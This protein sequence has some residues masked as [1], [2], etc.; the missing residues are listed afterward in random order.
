[1]QDPVGLKG[2]VQGPGQDPIGLKGA[3][4]DPIGLKE[5]VQNPVNLREVRLPW[6]LS[7]STGPRLSYRGRAA[8]LWALRGKIGPSQ[9]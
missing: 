9:P 1:M 2:A 6:L 8:P 3:V 4:K 5:A 7:R